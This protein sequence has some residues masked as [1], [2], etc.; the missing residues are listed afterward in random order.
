M[1]SGQKFSTVNYLFDTALYLSRRRRA[2]INAP[3]AEKEPFFL[4]KFAA[5][6]NIDTLKTIKPDFEIALELFS[7]DGEFVKSLEEENLLGAG[8]KIRAI[9]LYEPSFA[10]F[11]NKACI[12]DIDDL[13]LEENSYDLIIANC[14]LNWVNDLPGFLSRLKRA[15]KKDGL[16][17]ASFLGGRTL[18]ELREAFLQTEAKETGGAAMRISP[19]IELESAAALLR[20]AGFASP[21]SSSEVLR[22]RYDN[23][24]ALIRDLKSMG[25]NAAFYSKGGTKLTRSVVAGAANY[26]QDNFA[27]A[28]GRVGA[29]FEVITISAWN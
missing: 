14:G 6:G 2:I 28:D 21:V 7:G 12:N 17:I 24:F 23:M 27:D 10:E 26:Y 5:E 29:T 8:K 22:V 16:L 1:E 4:G 19:M 9:K 13:P 3:F 11:E 25:E 18:F 20:R 15:L